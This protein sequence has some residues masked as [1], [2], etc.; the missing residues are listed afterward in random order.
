MRSARKKEEHKKEGEVEEG[1]DHQGLSGVHVEGEE[2]VEE[3]V[4][5]AA[6]HERQRN[7][8]ESTCI[9]NM[10]PYLVGFLFFCKLIS[11]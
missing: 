10:S 7:V 6:I 3:H 9:K 5:T 4:S 11:T 8:Q 1:V 2:V